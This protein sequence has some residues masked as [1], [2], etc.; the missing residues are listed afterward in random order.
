MSGPHTED[1]SGV[2]EPER[3]DEPKQR[4]A[5]RHLADGPGEERDDE[6]Y[7]EPILPDHSHGWDDA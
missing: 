7:G 6:D 1:S 2:I 3:V 4:A 5:Y